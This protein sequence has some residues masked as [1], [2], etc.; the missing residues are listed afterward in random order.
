MNEPF[1]SGM[2]AAGCN[3]WASHAG[4]HMWR[5][6]S[7]ETVAADLKLLGENHLKTLRV[8][9]LWPD[10]QPLNRL[11]RNPGNKVLYSGEEPLPD[12]EA[13]RAGVS[14]EMMARFR[15]LA[16]EAGRNGI[17][18]IVGLITGWMSGRLFVPPAFE[19]LDLLSDPLAVK[20]QVRFVRYFV[21]N[22]KDHPAI[23]AWDLGN[24]CNCLG[25]PENSAAAW[26]WTNAI[27]SAIRLEDP[28][29]PVVSG[30][31]SLHVDGKHSWLIAD[32]AELTDIL[33]THPYPLFT[34]QCHRE[35]FNTIRNTLHATAES[36]LYG[37]IGGKPCLPEEVGC[38]GPMICSEERAG[39][40]L[41]SVLFSC[42]AHDLRGLLWWCAFDQ[43]HLPHAPY[44]WVALERE[45]GLFRSDRS[46]KPVVKAFEQFNRALA[47]LPF[48]K[49]PARRIDAVCLLTAGQE[50]W[51]TAFGAFILAKQAGFDLVFHD[52]ENPLPEAEIYLMP[53]IRGYGPVTAR[54]YR[55]LLGKIEKG[56]KLLVTAGNG[57]LQP[58][59][60]V[61]GIR[62]DYRHEEEYLETFTVEGVEHEFSLPVGLRQKLL[63][64]RAETPGRN[65][66]G[67][68]V[69]SRCRYGNGEAWFLN[70]PLE[71]TLIDTGGAFYGEKAQPFYRIYR[72]FFLESGC[73]RLI[74]RDHP[75]VGV[76][77]H[78][79]DE[80][81]VIG[82]LVNYCPEKAV[83][84]F[85]AAPG[86]GA[87]KALYGDFAE[88]PGNDAAIVQLKR[89]P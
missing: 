15:F 2:F 9:P 28:D 3:Y 6:W 59:E 54:R 30:M 23:A 12:T 72:K 57:M 50:H 26:N 18:L 67:D 70:M 62:T 43:E 65:S 25:T 79:L 55:E 42:W 14:G 22:L 82:V 81:T 44:D 47:S 5:D 45:L 32:Q 68:P 51:R 66:S 21:R 7:P 27:A 73:E 29:R 39:E 11:C 63:N 13:G 40:H 20:W 1:E 69:L 46:A 33:T 88:I 10:F 80:D 78:R 84:G 24:E 16:D 48:P 41:R 58:F 49:L 34:P 17:R 4:T 76:T 71:E 60:K 56:G 83:T 8:F 77:E 31:H 74:S 38:L 37:D 19:D 64:V 53:S 75:Q 36:C 89:T 86:W 85:R 87:A 35:P 61:F 52:A